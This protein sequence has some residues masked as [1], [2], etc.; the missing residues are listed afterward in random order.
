M[1]K[2]NHHTKG[3]VKIN[4]LGKPIYKI[5]IGSNSDNFLIIYE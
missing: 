2:D 4:I 3:K 5:N 1:L